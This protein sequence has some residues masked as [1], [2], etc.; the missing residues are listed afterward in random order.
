MMLGGVGVGGREAGGTHFPSCCPPYFP[1]PNPPSL[2]LLFI[3]LSVPFSLPMCLLLFSPSPFPAPSSLGLFLD[4]FSLSLLVFSLS[5]VFPIP[6]LFPVA[7]CLPSSSL[8]FLFSLSFYSL[9]FLLLLSFPLVKSKSSRL[10]ENLLNDYD[11][12]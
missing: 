8:S 9:S 2:F 4:L 1:F 3:P 12:L 11:Q 6:S 5:S 10:S 7:L